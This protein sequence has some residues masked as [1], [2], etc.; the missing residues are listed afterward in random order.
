MTKDLIES[1]MK[2]FA[3]GAKDTYG[4][5][6]KEVILYGSCARGD[7]D[8]ESDVDVMVLLDIPKQEEGAERVKLRNI[9]HNLDKKY[10]YEMLF[11]PVVVSYNNFYEWADALPFYKNVKSE[12]IRYV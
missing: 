4:E 12:G 8:N 6:L 10:D 7:F 3:T 5:M 11:V 1:A 2:D 9:I